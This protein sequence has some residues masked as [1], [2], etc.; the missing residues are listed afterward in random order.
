V[1]GSVDTEH[2][3]KIHGIRHVYPEVSQIVVDRLDELLGR[4]CRGPQFIHT[5]PRTDLRNY[6]E[7]VGVRM[8]S[9][10]DLLVRD[11]PTI[12]VAGVEVVYALRD[13]LAQHGQSGAAVLGRS[14]DAGPGQLHGS[15]AKSP[16]DAVA[17]GEHG[18]LIELWHDPIS[19][20]IPALAR[21]GSV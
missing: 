19:W 16:H 6:Q 7:I 11:V 21:A 14:K 12:E 13:R 5:T 3:S 18:G 10:A 8:E 15:K 4:R 20:K 2:A 1:R 9:F 17:E